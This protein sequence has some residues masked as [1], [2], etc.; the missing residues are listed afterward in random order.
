MPK[1]EDK[2]L[3]VTPKHIYVSWKYH[4]CLLLDSTQV[5][6]NRHYRYSKQI[7]LA[8]PCLH[9]ISSLLT[10]RVLTYIREASWCLWL[11]SLGL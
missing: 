3:K 5:T 1:H 6:Y 7:W 4:D 8:Q 11:R 10:V 9:H 2:A